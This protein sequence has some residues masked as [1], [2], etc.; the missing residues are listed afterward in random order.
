MSGSIRYGE[1]EIRFD[2]V[3]N[4]LLDSKVR[5]HVYPNARVEVE[6]PHGT[7]PKAVTAA[8]TKRARWITSQL[9]EME[10]TRR[11]ALV[12]EYVSGETH[13]YLGRRYQ[14]KVVEDR[15]AGSL[16]QLKGGLLRIVLP[17]ANATAVKR[18]LN[19]WYRERAGIY[20]RKRLVE[21]IG[22]TPWVEQTPS[23]SLVTC[24]SAA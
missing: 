17:R 2:V 22:K 6:V 15:D 13:F 21:L 4:D 8:V 9:L 10:E 1:R 18:R 7:L 19:V 11:H 20:F 3:L 14:L 23:V 12:R 24:R 5:I 16:V